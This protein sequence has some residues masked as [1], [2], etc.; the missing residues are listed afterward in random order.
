MLRAKISHNRNVVFSDLTSSYESIFQPPEVCPQ[1]VGARL[2]TKLL[3]SVSLETT[4]WGKN[5][6][7]EEM[8]QRVCVSSPLQPTNTQTDL[9]K[10]G[11]NFT[12]QSK[13]RK[14]QQDSQTRTSGLAFATARWSKWRFYRG[15]DQ[16]QVRSHLVT[17][18]KADGHLW[19][20]L[21]NFFSTDSPA[22]G[23]SLQD[24][25][26]GRTVILPL[27]SSLYVPWLFML[28]PS[29]ILYKPLKDPIPEF[30][31]STGRQNFSKCDP[32]TAHFQRGREC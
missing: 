20:R 7:V 23:T 24:P 25:V 16:P 17:R 31:F 11:L 22:I 14:R 5:S 10:E 28:G 15:D 8:N 21:R 12:V 4:Q 19:S 26:P 13:E 29:P 18:C 32:C 2:P 6:L 3:T 9:D 30:I 27:P 1:G